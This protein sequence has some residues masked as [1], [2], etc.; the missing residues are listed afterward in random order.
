LRHRCANPRRQG[1]T[2][3]TATEYYLNRKQA[4]FLTAK[5]ET[6]EATEITI[7]I[8]ERFDAYER[9]MMPPKISG[10]LET[11]ALRNWIIV[12][13]SERLARLEKKVDAAL[14][15]FDPTQNKLKT[16]TPRCRS[17]ATRTPPKWGRRGTPL[18]GG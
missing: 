9:G 8:I 3:C 7:E 18:D 13:Q 16:S 17:C 15:G 6:A 4:T 10:A 5:S 11:I 14:W 12:E 2:A 1:R